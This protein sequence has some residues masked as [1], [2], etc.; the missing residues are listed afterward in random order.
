[1]PLSK[2]LLL[3]IIGIVTIALAISV[4]MC[5]Q[6]PEKTNS[7]ENIA[8]LLPKDYTYMVF[9][10]KEGYG[11]FVSSLSSS[12]IDLKNLGIKEGDLLIGRKNESIIIMISKLSLGD[13]MK[14]EEYLV[15]NAPPDVKIE[16]YHGYEIWTL[17]SEEGGVAFRGDRFVASSSIKDYLDFLTEPKETFYDNEDVRYMAKRLPYGIINIIRLPEKDEKLEAIGFSIVR[18]I[19]NDSYEAFLIVKPITKR[20]A[21]EIK[22]SIEQGTPSKNFKCEIFDEYIECR[23]TMEKKVATEVVESLI[24]YRH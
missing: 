10:T 13:M 2:K 23:G 16:K 3:P 19:S 20:E 21:K 22:E 15:K 9:I 1:M 14:I 8:K 7:L 18:K 17:P 4:S 11:E 12:E 6:K 5:V 24:E